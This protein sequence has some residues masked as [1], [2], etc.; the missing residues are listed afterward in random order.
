MVRAKK[1]EVKKVCFKTKSGKEVVFSPGSSSAASKAKLSRAKSIEKRL[2]IMEKAILDYNKKVEE[3]NAR[4]SDK[5]ELLPPG[6]K[7]RPETSK[8]FGK[9]VDLE[10]SVGKAPKSG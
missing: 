4:K 8:K 9:V 3:H 1:S 2:S 5:S 10:K 6:K 7:V